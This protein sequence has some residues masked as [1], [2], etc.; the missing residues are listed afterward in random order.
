MGD[1]TKI[2]WTDATWNPA[3]GCSRVSDGCRNCYAETLS[4]RRGWSKKPWTA[5]NAKYNV[6]LHPERLRKPYSWKGSQRVFVNSMSDLFHELIPDDFIAKVFHVM[7]DFPQHTF[8]ILT[9]RPERAAA[10]SGPWGDNIWQGV[11]VEDAK[12]ANRIDVLRK[13]KAQTLFISYEP[14]LGSLGDIDLTGYRWL[15]VGGE[16]GPGFRKMDMAWAREARDLCQKYGLA[17]FFKQDSAFR[18]ETRPWLI[19]PDGSRWHWQQ[20]P[21][22]TIEAPRFIERNL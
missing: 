1:T 12:T 22:T 19:E 14:A 17:F 6:V 7:N 8:Q 5:V 10:W 20:Y 13:C 11:S 18:T 15:I 21:N 3:T 2:A 16:S 9:K 4:L